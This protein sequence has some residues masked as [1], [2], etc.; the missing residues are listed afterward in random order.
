MKYVL[1]T[2]KMT[3]GVGDG[4]TK[5]RPN[6]AACQPNKVLPALLLVEP[7]IILCNGTTISTYD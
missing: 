2:V 7:S 5:I 3:L 4:L 1:K 6:V